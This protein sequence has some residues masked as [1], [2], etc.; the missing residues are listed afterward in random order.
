[1]AHTTVRIGITARVDEPNRWERGD[2]I[3]VGESEQLAEIAESAPP[4]LADELIVSHW[5][6]S[7]DVGP[8][9]ECTKERKTPSIAFAGVSQAILGDDGGRRGSTSPFGDR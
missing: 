9:V 7:Q 1:M 3:W 6:A 5:A 8:G 2:A 4:E